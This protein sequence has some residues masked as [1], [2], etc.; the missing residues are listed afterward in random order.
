MTHIHKMLE[1][2]FKYNCMHRIQRICERV[3]QIPE[4]KNYED[5]ERSVKCYG[6][7]ACLQSGQFA[8]AF[9]FLKYLVKLNHNDNYIVVLFNIVLRNIENPNVFKSF[10]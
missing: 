6:L 9:A 1:I 8:R 5:V 10:L 7:L 2:L 4:L 3:S